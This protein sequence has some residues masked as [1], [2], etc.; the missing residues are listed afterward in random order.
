ML[1]L[2]LAAF[3]VWS[4]HARVYNDYYEYYDTDYDEDDSSAAVNEIHSD[5]G[6]AGASPTETTK[7]SVR[8][9]E[10]ISVKNG[11]FVIQIG[12]RFSDV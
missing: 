5:F 3:V 4:A 12:D 7:I 6:D 11:M 10:K 8:F 9:L 1:V 2:Y